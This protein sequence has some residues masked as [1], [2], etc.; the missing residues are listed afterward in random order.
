MVDHGLELNS[1]KR[2]THHNSVSISQTTDQEFH[3]KNGMSLPPI[4]KP[5]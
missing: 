5:H 2:M 4:R 1:P 3:K